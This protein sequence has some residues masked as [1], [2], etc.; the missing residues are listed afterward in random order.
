MASGKTLISN[1]GRRVITAAGKVAAAL[2]SGTK[3]A[4]CAC[5]GCTQ[6]VLASPCHVSLNESCDV[7]PD[8]GFWVKAC[9]SC[10]GGSKF[11]DADA[12]IYL[13]VEGLG[14]KCYKTDKRTLTP[15]SAV[16]GGATVA[17]A[18]DG[19]TCKPSCAHA[20]CGS[21]SAPAG[22]C[23]CLCYNYDASVPAYCCWGKKNALGNAVGIS[24]DLLWTV[25][26]TVSRSERGGFNPL[27]ACPDT[28]ARAGASCV[29]SRTEIRTK[30]TPTIS[31]CCVT[32]QREQRTPISKTAFVAGLGTVGCCSAANAGSDTWADIAADTL[33]VTDF[34]PLVHT[35][36]VIVLV[37]RTDW[38]SSGCYS[39][40]TRTTD[41]KGDCD[42]LTTTITDEVWAF[43]QD[44]ENCVYQQYEKIVETK[45][46]TFTRNITAAVGVL[47]QQCRD[48]LTA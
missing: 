12:V 30:G 22:F 10:G 20:D 43:Q 13:Y 39:Y 38:F 48:E 2:T 21:Y 19:W 17:D 24:W 11:Q 16:P 42:G 34:P 15:I 18:G 23:T 32:R 37:D 25:E 5:C 41:T 27:A 46:F 4:A 29:W 35:H 47:C 1:I 36:E 40:A 44:G 31:G 6:A 33:C 45:K 7:I 28:D 26:K 9:N 3:D 8:Y 14:Y